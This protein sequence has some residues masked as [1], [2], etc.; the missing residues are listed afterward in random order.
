M[1]DKVLIANRGAIACRIEHTLKR[2]GI[3]S[4]AVYSEAD[5]ESRHVLEAHE[6]V[7]LGASP[8]SESYLLAE[9]V[10]AAALATGASA[11]HPGYGFLSENLEFARLCDTNGI[12]FVGPRV[13][14]IE[15]FELKHR[16]REIAIECAV[17]LLPG[18]LSA[19]NATSSI[20]NVPTHNVVDDLTWV[21]GKHTLQFGANYRLIF[22][23]RSSDATLYN[24]AGVTYELL[25]VGAIA[26]TSVARQP[27]AS[28]DPAGF[29]LPAVSGNYNAAYNTAVADI[30]GLITSASQ[31]YNNKYSSGELTPLPAGQWVD[32]QYVTN[33]F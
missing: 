2:M 12:C 9:K 19:T 10:V 16:A 6:A 18:T 5:R 13:Q 21:K 33:H 15:A 23:S 22:N 27:P 24:S 20:V 25:A 29:G 28:L 7:L 26:N 3:R 31:Y 1:F 14:H 17:P 4:V 30:T 32:H 11:V 8:A